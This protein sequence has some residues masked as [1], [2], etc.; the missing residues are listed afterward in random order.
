MHTVKTLLAATAALLQAVSAVNLYVSSYDGNVTTLSLTGS[1]GNYTL[2][3]SSRIQGCGTQPSWLVYDKPNSVLYCMDENWNFSPANPQS[4]FTS[5]TVDQSSGKLSLAQTS[6]MS[7]ASSVNGVLFGN[8][9][10]FMAVAGYSGQV[11]ALTVNGTAFKQ[12]QVLNFVNKTELG[13]GQTSPHP[14]QTVLDP[15]GQYIVTPDLG[16]DLLR[17]FCWDDATGNDILEEHPTFKAASGSGPRHAAFWKADPASNTTDDTYLF[18]VTEIASTLTAYK[19]S[20]PTEGG[21][22]FTQVDTQNTF[23]GSTTPNGAKAAEVHV[24]PDNKYLIVSNRNDSSFS[25]VESFGGASNVTEPSDSLATYEINANG[26][27][28]F[29]Q[30]WAAG[31]LFPRQFSINKAGD[32]VA[33]GLQES[34]RVVILA[35]DVDSGLLG[36]PVAFTTVGTCADG[37]LAGPT[38]IVWDE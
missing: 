35:R 12:E 19:V 7:T 14:H 17:V 27:L 13:P 5:Y 32:M 34:C 36:Q 11:S 26:T 8:N 30:L 23:G 38:R 18:V 15:T 16:G 22:N 25:L 1:S 9:K 28:T 6:N 33:V 21:L 3:E 37:N 24:S 20:Y 29:K 4:I 31:G 2:S 10:E